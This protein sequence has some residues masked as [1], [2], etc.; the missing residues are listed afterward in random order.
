ML[1]P[2]F[3]FLISGD[4]DYV[5]FIFLFPGPGSE[6]VFRNCPLKEHLA[7]EMSKRQ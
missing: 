6:Q 5:R 4:R 3:D 1:F 7:R 2:L